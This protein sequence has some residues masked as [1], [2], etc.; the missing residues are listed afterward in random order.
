MTAN[1]FF[2]LAAIGPNLFAGTLNGVFISNDNG[3]TW[4]PTNY[5]YNA[6]AMAAVGTNLFIGDNDGGVSV[7]PDNGNTWNPVDSG[8]PLKDIHVL[9]ASG[10]ELF[11]G[12]N[13]DAGGTGGLFRTTNN[14]AIWTRVNGLPD[15]AA[16]NAI[17]VNGSYLF[18]GTDSD[19]FLSTDNGVNWRDVSGALNDT[20][21]PTSV[22]AYSFTV[23]DDTLYAGTQRGVWMSLLPFF[24]AVTPNAPTTT[25]LT[26]YPNPFADKTTINFLSPESGAVEVTVV[27][28]LGSEVARIFDG[29]LDAGQHE[30]SWDASTMPPGMYECIVR[31]NGQAERMPMVI[32]R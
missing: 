1:M 21:Y 7:S 27:N 19:V 20:I 6:F 18:A 12:A 24:L 3:N 26:S 2:A 22:S 23:N 8:L 13:F 28:L 29:E 4:N 32:V 30:F 11:A 15:T 31:M 25:S 5:E 14:G 10:N 17:F 9:T 16:I